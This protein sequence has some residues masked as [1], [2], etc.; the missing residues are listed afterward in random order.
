LQF[1]Y[2]ESSLVVEHFI[3]KYGI[4]ALKKVLDNLAVGMPINEALA[5][6]AGSIEALNQEFA[7]Y[8]RK[9]AEEFAPSAEWAEPEIPARADVAQIGEWVRKHPLEVRGWLLYGRRLMEDRQWKAA[10]QALEQAVELAPDQ[11]GQE[12]AYVLLAQVFRESGDTGREKAVL[13]EVASRDAD[14]LAVRLR[15]AEICSQEQDW[16]GALEHAQQALA[17][18]PLAPAPHRALAAAAEALGDRAAAIQAQRAILT[19]APTDPAGQ[20][21]SLS[22]LLL[23]DNQLALARRHVLMALEEAPRYRAAHATLLEIVALDAKDEPIEP[24]APEPPALE[25]PAP[26]P[27]APAATPVGAAP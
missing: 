11:K 9:K 25:P 24:P 21:H 22:R 5:R 19:L 2:Y 14:A 10:E 16:S 23:A 1:A 15:L 13:K 17:I 26:E 4:D 8:A 18:N 20:H 7:E 27:T 12:S 3:A 6:H